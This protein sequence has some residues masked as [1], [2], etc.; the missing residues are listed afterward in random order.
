M[1]A[2]SSIYHSLSLK[3]TGP[4]TF[5]DEECIGP[6]KVCRAMLNISKIRP[7]SI[8]GGKKKQKENSFH[9]VCTPAGVVI[10]YLV[11]MPIQGVYKPYK[12]DVC[13]WESKHVPSLKSHLPIQAHNHIK[14][15]CFHVKPCLYI[16]TSSTLSAHIQRACIQVWLIYVHAP[17]IFYWFVNTSHWQFKES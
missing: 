11:R 1:R 7:K 16:N 4:Q 15:T 10:K 13:W 14:S 17:L 12:A 2:S 5:T 9:G 3:L 6:L 8:I